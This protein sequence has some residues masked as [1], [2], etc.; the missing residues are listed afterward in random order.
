MSK[1]GDIVSEEVFVNGF[2]ILKD[3]YK[4]QDHHLVDVNLRLIR[5]YF[6]LLDDRAVKQFYKTYIATD[7]V[8]AVPELCSSEIVS[9]PKNMTGVREYRF[10]ST[11]A[12]ILYTAFGLV[13]VECSMP[14]I[15][16]LE[17]KSKG[18][19]SFF[20]TRFIHGR[21]KEWEVKNKYREEYANFTKKLT[22]EIEPGDVVIKTD[23]SSYFENISHRKLLE[24]LE[25]FS[26]LSSL[27]EHNIKDESYGSLEFYLDN[28]MQGKLGVPQ[29]RKN[30]TS[31]F[32]G[33]F[34]LVPF[35]N[36]IRNL[37]ISSKLEFKACIRYVDDT[38]IVFKNKCKNNAEANKE[39]L[40]VEQK[41]SSWIF[42]ELGLGIS[43]AKTERVIISNDSE[44]N[45]FIH[46]S[47]KSVSQ[48]DKK[49]VLLSSGQKVDFTDLKAALEKLK[50]DESTSFKTGFFSKDDRESLK[51][52][53]SS[54]FQKA[55]K[56]KKNRDDI[57]SLLKNIDI[58]I[59]V[60]EIN[61]M[62]P[63]FTQGSDDRFEKVI[64]SILSNRSLDLE[65]RRIVHII[66]AILTRFKAPN[67]LKALAEKRSVIARDSYGKYLA[68]ALGTSVEKEGIAGRINKEFNVKKRKAFKKHLALDSLY[69]EIVFE[70]IKEGIWSEP[71]VQAIRLYNYEVS[72]ERWDTAFNQLQSTFHEIMKSHYKLGDSANIQEIS[73]HLTFL[74]PR[75]EL[76]LRKFYDR[77]NFNPISHPSKK[78]MPAEKVGL[79]ELTQ[80]RND[81][82][83]IIQTCFIHWKGVK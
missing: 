20:P 62:V 19:Y 69:N 26:P 63:L 2:H 78:G 31:D 8:Y 22:D 49:A 21:K 46:K 75:Q 5:P 37:C 43:P 73:K 11:F 57:L 72:L 34:Y 81:I 55:M 48:S 67:Q 47:S 28:L 79:R 83:T 70:I 60:D 32:F 44:K 65:D 80:Y 1:L 30:F 18:V 54:S 15:E 9:V 51:F 58:E 10:M 29:G 66:L 13:F 14:L 27:R 82:L 77:R 41:I 17:F 6:D 61:I 3:Y 4:N 38:F 74:S 7:L 25:E 52:V 35:D 45:D 39:L 71:L 76:T 23:I 36:E 12:H 33:Y 16:S 68:I 50:F 40:R 24:L 59:T 56:K 64:A 53:F 42:T